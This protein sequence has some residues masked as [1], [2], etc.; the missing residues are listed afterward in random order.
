MDITCSGQ[1]SV[2][3]GAH[4]PSAPAGAPRYGS[5]RRAG[6]SRY[7]RRCYSGFVPARS[8]NS[9]SEEVARSL[10]ALAV[11][12]RSLS[13]GVVEAD[14]RH[15]PVET[16]RSVSQTEAEGLVRILAGRIVVADRISTAARRSLGDGGVA[17]L[18]RRG[19]LQLRGETVHIDADVPPLV[20]PEPTRVSELFVPTGMDI[21]I[22]LLLDPE[23]DHRTMDVATLVGRSPGRVSEILAAM[24]ERGLIDRR[25]RPAIP[26][27]FNEMAD[28]W[29]PSWRSLGSLP[30]PDA[31]LFRLSGTLGAVWHQAPVIATADWPAEVYVENQSELRALLRSHG[32]PPGMPSA[33]R[34]AVCPSRYGWLVPAEFPHEG[35][36][37][38][39]HVVVALDLAQDRG[40]GREILA[41][42]DPEGHVRVW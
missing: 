41:S 21:G 23:K 1:Y 15:I 36:P 40:R 7:R 10:R 42:W 38:A 39:N 13:P 6:I 34:A 29:A 5:L 2:L 27:F 14:G 25:G 32:A 8:T 4:Q 11:P 31:E 30:Q 18:D 26:E 3:S 16:R 24:R 28:G 12:A 33:G 20:R 19:H 22:A 17:W 35:F 9:P 37:V